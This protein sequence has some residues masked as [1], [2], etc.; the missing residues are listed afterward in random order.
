MRSFMDDDF[1]LTTPTASALYHRYAKTQPIIDYHCH[2]SPKEIYEDRQF[3]N[4]S[5]V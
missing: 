1:L 2:V 4:I 5:Q 3:D